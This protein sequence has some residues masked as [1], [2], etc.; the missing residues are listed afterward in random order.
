MIFF[1]ILEINTG[2]INEIIFE[3]V[4]WSVGTVKNTPKLQSSHIREHWITTVLYIDL[5]PNWQ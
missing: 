3:L 5:I 4:N 2:K 1:V